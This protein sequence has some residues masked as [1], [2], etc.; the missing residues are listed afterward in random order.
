[1]RVTGLE[2]DTAYPFRVQISGKT[3]G[4][5]NLRTHAERATKLRFFVMGDY[6]S[7]GTP[8]Y[9]VSE[10]MWTEFERHANSDNP[11]RFLITTGDNIYG[12]Q[13]GL[14]VRNSGDRDKH[15]LTRYYAP[16]DK[17]LRRIPFYPSLGNHDG[18]ES[19]NRGDLDVYMD[20]FAFPAFQPARWYQFRYAN[21]AQFFALDSTENNL[22]GKKAWIKGGG[23]E[24]WLKESL[25]APAPPWRIAYWHHPPFT[26]GPHHDSSLAWLQSAVDLLAENGAQV[27]FNGHE[28]NFQISKRNAAT[29]GVQYIVSGS[30]GELRDDGVQSLLEATNMLAWSPQRQFL[31]VEIDGDTMRVQPIGFERIKAVNS[32]GENFPFPFSIPRAK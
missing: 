25:A 10:A 20:N 28:H 17:L 24:K 9:K 26:A 30:A 11:V 19:E 1:M 8:Q 21:L 22:A 29:K 12:L 31:S 16:Y 3:F 15:W 32:K 2:P 4:E 5:G 7:G 6:G 23:Q 18:N 13:F 27:V 14:Y